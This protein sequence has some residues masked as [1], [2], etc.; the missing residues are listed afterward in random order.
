MQS[1]WWTS[2]QLLAEDEQLVVDIALAHILHSRP[3]R[4]TI[5]VCLQLAVCA[6]A[7]PKTWSGARL[8]TVPLLQE[9]CQKAVRLLQGSPGKI[10]N[11][12][13][14]LLRLTA[15]RQAEGFGADAQL[16]AAG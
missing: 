7:T 10:W 5:A 9:L 14:C 13:P 6:F 11:E 3:I 2:K 12:R 16:L 1:I 15:C 8:Q 4:G